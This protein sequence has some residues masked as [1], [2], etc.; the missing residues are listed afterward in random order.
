M[1]VIHSKRDFGPE[2]NQGCQTGSWRCFF[3]WYFLGIMMKIGTVIPRLTRLAWQPKNRV[4]RN[5]RYASQSVT[6]LYIQ[7]NG[8]NTIVEVQFSEN[9]IME[10]NLMKI[11]LWK[12]NLKNVFKIFVLQRNRVMRNFTIYLCIKPRYENFFGHPQK[13]VL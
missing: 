11:Q 6:F 8:E 7:V 4:R 5:S 13:T 10:Y 2:G 12:Y 3:P 9:T 1:S